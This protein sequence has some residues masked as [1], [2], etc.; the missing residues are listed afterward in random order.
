MEDG[1]GGFM[2]DLYF[3]GGNFG[4]VDPHYASMYI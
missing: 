4:F 1:S 3:S 2:T